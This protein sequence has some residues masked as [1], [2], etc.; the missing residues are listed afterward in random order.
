MSLIWSYLIWSIDLSTDLSIYLSILSYLILS[1]L[2]LS[3]QSILM[4]ADLMPPGL[5][6]PPHRPARQWQVLQGPAQLTPRPLARKMWLGTLRKRSAKRLCRVPLR[7]F[8]G[9]PFWSPGDL[10]HNFKWWIC[11]ALGVGMYAIEVFF[12]PLGDWLMWDQ[13][14]G[15]NSDHFAET[16]SRGRLILHM[17]SHLHPQGPK[18]SKINWTTACYEDGIGRHMQV[19]W[20]NGTPIAGWFIGK[21]R[22]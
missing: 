11:W 19:S 13:W 17:A 5:T 14:W 16:T 22:K 8:W 9:T 7:R 20:N 21:I 18:K 1:Y 15:W 2:I 6:P 10:S 4:L 3:H 12:F